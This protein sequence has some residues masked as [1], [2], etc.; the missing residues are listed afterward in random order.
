MTAERTNQQPASE[1]KPRNELRLIESAMHDQA[2]IDTL[3]RSLTARPPHEAA[4]GVVGV[5]PAAHRWKKSR[6]QGNPSR[7][8]KR[9]TVRFRNLPTGS[10]IS[11]IGRERLSPAQAAT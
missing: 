9:R 4:I 10:A 6:P 3:S 5:P 8:S 7:N 2:D 11:P 1:S